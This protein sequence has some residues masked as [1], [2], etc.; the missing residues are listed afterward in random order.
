[1]QVKIRRRTSNATCGHVIKSGER[2][3]KVFI[4]S[5]AYNDYSTYCSECAHRVWAAMLQKALRELRS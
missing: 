3:L 2:Y 4:A 5:E 1:M